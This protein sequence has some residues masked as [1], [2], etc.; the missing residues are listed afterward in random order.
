MATD[1]PNTKLYNL[2]DTPAAMVYGQFGDAQVRLD[3]N[4]IIDVTGYR[5]VSVRIGPTK[6]SS[7][8]LTM[9]KISG[10]TLAVEHMRPIDNAIHTFEVLGPEIA[11]VLKGGAPKSREKVQLWVYLRS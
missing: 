9:G 10:A 11:L 1:V 2:V 6:A 7:W 5:Q 4:P 3:T 8:S